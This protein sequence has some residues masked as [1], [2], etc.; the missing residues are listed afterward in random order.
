L[1]ARARER[2]AEQEWELSLLDPEDPDERA[3]LIRLA[4]PDLDEAIEF[5]LEEIVVGGEPMNPRLHL[6]IHE[7]VATQVID[8]DPPEAFTTLQRLVQSG[9]DPHGALHMVASV[10]SAQLWTAMHERRPYEREE[11]VR[12][13]AALPDSWDAQAGG[14]GVRQERPAGHRSSRRRRGR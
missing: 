11:H 2:A 3:I 1:D 10:V 5:G 12:A 6:A 7:V 13:L 4:H 14:A 8:Y 9:R